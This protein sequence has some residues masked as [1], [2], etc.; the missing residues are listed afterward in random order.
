[1]R[2]YA[3]ILLAVAAAG[4]SHEEPVKEEVL[5]RNGYYLL[6]DLRDEVIDYYLNLP[7]VEKATPWLKGSCLEI[8]SS[9]RCWPE[10][11]NAWTTRAPLRYRVDCG[12]R[13]PDSDDPAYIATIKEAIAHHKNVIAAWLLPDHIL[14]VR[15]RANI[16][17]DGRK[18]HPFSYERDFDT[19]EANM[20]RR[21]AEE[22]VVEVVPVKTRVVYVEKEDLW[23]KY[24]EGRRLKKVAEELLPEG[25]IEN[26]CR[27]TPRG[28]GRIKRDPLDNNNA[29]D[30]AATDYAKKGSGEIVNVT[31]W[32][33]RDGVPDLEQYTHNAV[34]KRVGHKLKRVDGQYVQCSRRNLKF[35][36]CPID[37]MVVWAST[38]NI[39]VHI[40]SHRG[41]PEEIVRAYLKLYPSVLTEKDGFD[42]AAWAK[43]NFEYRLRETDKFLQMD[44]KY[45]AG[46]GA[47]VQLGCLDTTWKIPGYVPPAGQ[48]APQELELYRA[49]LEFY[50][51][52]WEENKDRP[53]L[54]DEREGEYYFDPKVPA[55]KRK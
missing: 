19:S 41:F 34:S 36:E 43:K 24:E 28:G 29:G 30:Y 9:R 47:R 53:V 39:Y 38:G 21:K 42:P 55:K 44:D 26:Y 5:W 18:H 11:A 14:V 46:T 10:N 37:W 32:R 13:E 40:D 31:V 3:V 27:I 33:Y 52:W 17:E 49:K 12:Y 54:F 35:E 8:Y 48:P 25:N 6:F 2:R 4:W 51:K 1:M 23:A 45:V 20:A 7:E 15:K 50:R 16:P 22:G